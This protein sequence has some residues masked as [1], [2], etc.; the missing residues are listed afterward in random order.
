M[1]FS[2]SYE[3]WRDFYVLKVEGKLNGLHFAARC[4]LKLIM[5]QLEA[6]ILGGKSRRAQQSERLWM[7][8]SLSYDLSK[9][10]RDIQFSKYIWNCVS[11]DDSRNPLCHRN[12]SSVAVFYV[13]ANSLK[14]NC[15]YIFSLQVT[16]DDN[17]TISSQKVQVVTVI[18]NKILQVTIECVRNCQRD[19]FLANVKVH[20]YARCLNCESQNVG[21][22]WYIDGQLVVTNRELIMHIRTSSNVTRISVLL[23]SEDGR[24]G[25]KS[26][27]LIKTSGPT[28][29]NCSIYPKEGDEA[30]TAFFPCCRNFVSSNNPIEFWYYVGPVLLGTCVDCNCEVYLPITNVIKVLICD[31][32]YACHTTWINVKINALK[33]IPY[34]VPNLLSKGLLHR[35][36]QTVQSITQH[37]S[38]PESGLI[39][40][41]NF[42][43]IL[44]QSRISLA[45]LANLTLTL[46]HRLYPEGQ[47][48]DILL[49][50]MA[51]KINDNFEEIYLD[52]DVNF[53][54]EQPFQSIRLAC[55]E[56]L[57]VMKRLCKRTRRPPW[58]IY[59]QY[60]QA[61][62]TGKLEQ[63][64]IEKLVA[65]TRTLGNE[66]AIFP[67]IFWLNSTWETERLY[68]HLDYPRGN[69]YRTDVGEKREMTPSAVTLDVQCFKTFPKKKIR[70]H[71]SDKIHLVI[72]TPAVFEEILGTNKGR[73]CLKVL[74]IKQQLHWWYP[75]EKK[76]SSLIVSV[77]IYQNEDNLPVPISL[78]RSHINYKTVNTYHNDTFFKT[79]RISSRSDDT[80]KAGIYVDCLREAELHTFRTVRIY[81]IMLMEHTMLAVHISRAT[82]KLQVVLTLRTKPLFR[83]ISK[84]KCTVPAR[85]KGK[86]LLLLNNCHQAQRAYMAVRLCS[87]VTIRNSPSTPVKN[88]PAEFSFA[89]QIRSCDHWSYSSHPDKEHWLQYGCY[90]AMTLSVRSGIRC[91]CDVLG[92]YTNYLYYIP[93][94]EVPGCVYSEAHINFFILAFYSILFSLIPLW[95]LWLYI[96]R[97]RFPSKTIFIPEFERKDTYTGELHDLLISLRT[98]GRLNSGTTASLKLVL[99]DPSEGER[100]I[101][102]KQDPEHPFLNANST[103]FL[104]IRTR[105]IR[106][107]TKVIVSHDNA[108]RFPSWF[109]RRIEVNDI[110][111]LETQVFI[112]RQFVAKKKLLLTSA[113]IYKRGDVRF[114]DK[115]KN[116]FCLNFEMLWINWSLWQPITGGWRET[117]QFP[118]MTRAK[119]F[120]VFIS[121]QFVAFTTCALYFGLTT[122]ESLQLFRDKFLDYKDLL[123]LTIFCCVLDSVLE[124]LFRAI[125]WKCC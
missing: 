104:W 3:L 8:G 41:R 60:Y 55:L 14:N 124:L 32:L 82:H 23:S 35:Y 58:P 74:S 53:L 71:T 86:T 70:V 107:P 75:L 97:N 69:I 15:R 96:Y 46:A 50:M 17:P 102:V 40:L 19:Y 122:T 44:P 29:G 106:I 95:I 33:N 7:N 37:L 38:N 115:W 11:Y 48:K 56:V 91:I 90:P 112:A 101:R 78:N 26:K 2:T 77:R 93:S 113:L 123:V 34:N 57:E 84:S 88:G 65:R 89:F 100:V 13:P 39:L 21:C 18:K 99:F 43:T 24:I 105:D 67:W 92:T 10:T 85:T 47:K 28:G 98:G 20:L 6:V 72:I 125:N 68:R 1:R 45:R 94:I 116:R 12:I 121:K 4:Y 66:K 54:A 81:R 61:Y 5:G 79:S 120:C 80:P 51:Q 30:V 73:A 111:T 109:L 87:N 9:R 27:T 52:D 110:Q 64:L 16:R 63:T 42:T 36:L 31:A 59:N 119:R 83:Q 76:P 103:L 62:I 117:S 108:G 114:F 118:R 49:T 22:K 25:R